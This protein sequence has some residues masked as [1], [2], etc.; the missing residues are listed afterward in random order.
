MPGL[1]HGSQIR[2][3]RRN[4]CALC[5]ALAKNL[6]FL[7]VFATPVQNHNPRVG[8]SSPSSATFALSRMVSH[9]VALSRKLSRKLPTLASLRGFLFCGPNRL[10]SHPVAWSRTESQPDAP[11]LLP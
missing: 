10:D 8:G 11:R 9:H 2:V 3:V 6:V 7:V 4:C 1:D 5:C